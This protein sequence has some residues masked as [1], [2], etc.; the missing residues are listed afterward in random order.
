ME[1]YDQ[2]L[3]P[4]HLVLEFVVTQVSLHQRRLQSQTFTFLYRVFIIITISRLFSC[5]LLLIALQAIITFSFKSD[6]FD[7]LSKPRRS[8]LLLTIH[9]RLAE[10]RATLGR[11]L[12]LRDLQ[13]DELSYSS[14][15]LAAHRLI[16]PF[17]IMLEL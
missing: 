17:I 14:L 10:K 7:H 8:L 16:T 11:G 15:I 1:V 3:L 9:H 13:L 6:V 12:I 2:L 4:I 5:L